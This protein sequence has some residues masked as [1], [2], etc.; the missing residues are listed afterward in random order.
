MNVQEYFSTQRKFS[1]S[2]KQKLEIFK[3][4]RQRRF[5]ISYAKWFSRSYK[6]IFTAIVLVVVFFWIWGFWVQRNWGIDNIF[7]STQP[8]I[9][10]TTFAD[11]IAEIVNVKG[12][13]Y[14]QNGNKITISS[15][16]HHGDTIY[17]KEK[18]EII[19][20]LDDGSQASIVGPAIF[21]LF[22]IA[23][24]QYQLQISEGQFIKLS[25]QQPQNS[26]ELI[27]DDM[28]LTTP[29]NQ[30]LDLQIAKN[31]NETMIQNHWAEIAAIIPTSSSSEN[32][33]T[34]SWK[35]I[36]IS[37]ET[38][39]IRPNDLR[40]LTDS[41]QFALFLEHNNL[42]EA[43]S[44]NEEISPTK[45]T[46][47]NTVSWI[48]APTTTENSIALNTSKKDDILETIIP[49]SSQE[50]TEKH[51]DLDPNIVS[52][53][54]GESEKK[55]PTSDQQDQLLH[56]LNSFF[57]M[58]TFEDI[59]LA[60]LTN[61]DAQR[62]IA[63]LRNK[64][65]NLQKTFQLKELTGTPWE[66]ALQLRDQLSTTYYVAPSQLQKLT[67]I[68]AWRKYLTTISNEG[69][70]DEDAKAKWEQIKT[71]LPKDLLLD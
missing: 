41:Q 43:F 20:H 70:S 44:L 51:W 60:K 65:I 48:S 64:L 47:D 32:Q 13:R 4:I 19:F 55:L 16:L 59:T 34:K 30:T 27:I 37:Q 49:S 68:N 66:M 57:L 46:G 54:G 56:T 17:L 21:S 62:H 15:Y 23:D 3:E 25:H 61:S 12:E 31:D 35:S 45:A 11:H 6:T 36:T 39:A 63:T 42:S 5:T 9:P 1:L 50:T 29:Q 18:S 58:N 26:R 8:Q 67:Q 38:I 2:D 7:F 28:I 69:M 14:L 71:Q 53:L 10:G 33:E 24:H 22:K 52:Q 40:H